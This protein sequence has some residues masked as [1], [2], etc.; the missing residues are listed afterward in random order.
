MD[1]KEFQELSGW[2]LWATG[3]VFVSDG[4]VIQKMLC[5]ALAGGNVLFEDYPGLGK[6][7]L[8]KIFAKVSGCSWGRVQ[9][10]PDMMP[11]DILGA[12]IWKD[13]RTGFILE[14]GPVFTNILLADEI[15]RAPPKTQSALLEAMEEKQVTIEGTTYRLEKPF[16]VIATQNPIELEGT[17]PLPEAQLDRFLLKM[18]TG[19][20]K[21]LEQESE[22][23]RHRIDWKTDDPVGLIDSAISRGQFVAMQELVESAV[24]V[25]G[26]I[27]DYVSQ[28]V[29]ATRE[30]PAVE[31]G[32]SPRGGLALLKLSRAYAAM[33]GR[34]FVT[35]DDIKI[36]AED[37]LGHRVIMNV[38]YEIEGMATPRS[39]VG[40]VVSGI[41][42][43]KDYVRQGFTRR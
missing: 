6:T 38:E 13:A 36:F 3:Q 30:H 42:P 35:P 8:A 15:N 7:L 26:Q 19:Y 43:P 5:A 18:T 39:V 4:V 17:F 41:E 9:F 21:T 14:K 31:V 20:A 29:R 23:L 27:L 2:I 33:C 16:F 22:I 37:A 25:D 32:S 24:Y 34:D 11:G 40:E 28:I 1:I 12:R 10:T